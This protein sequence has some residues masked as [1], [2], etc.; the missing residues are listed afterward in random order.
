M[1]RIYQIKEI[2]RVMTHKV[3]GTDLNEKGLPKAAANLKKK[4]T[5]TADHGSELNVSEEGDF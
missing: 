1:A 4:F 2:R 3:E 5:I